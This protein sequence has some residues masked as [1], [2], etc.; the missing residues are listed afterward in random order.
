MSIQLELQQKQVL[1]HRM[2]QSVQILQMTSQELEAYI[3]ELALENPVMEVDK[4]SKDSI[5]AWL[6]S[7]T[8]REEDHYLT[9]QQ[10]N[11]DDYDPKD[12]WNFQTDHG[13]TLMDHLWA[14]LDHRAFSQTELLI[15]Y[16]LLECLDERGYIAE[17]TAFVAE[18]FDVPEER[19]ENLLQVLQSLSP[20]GVC[21][22][23]LEECLRI[24]LKAKGELDRNLE[25]IIDNCLEEVSRNKIAWLTKKLGISPEE[26]AHYCDLIRSLDPRP[27]S[28]FYHQE[29]IQ[30]IIPDVYVLKN[31]GMFEVSLN[32]EEMPSVFVNSYYQKLFL[33]TADSELKDYLTQKIRQAEWLRHCI[34]QRQATLTKIAN[35]ILSRQ[36][37]FFEKGTGHLRPLS[38]AEA[39]AEIEVHEST[40]SRAVDKKYLQCSWGIFPMAYFFQR[41]ASVGGD[42]DRTFTAESVKKALQE[43]IEGENPKKPY[44]DRILSDKLGEMGIDISRRTVAKYREEEHIPDASGRKK[45]G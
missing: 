10:N 22:R 16:F 5:D 23:S 44:S 15:L 8:I 36:M 37:D 18:H 20:A 32:R 41:K 19:V 30:Y 17:D 29:T 1:S 13:E 35:V 9:Q 39:A 4:S 6:E 7:R 28:H 31:K 27:G 21:A 45:Q 3:D 14:Q 12:S 43:I 40:V 2:I 26:A 24:Q 33:D 25:F 38:M 34:E 42:G 11:D